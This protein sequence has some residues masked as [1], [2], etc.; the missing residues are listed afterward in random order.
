MLEVLFSFLS[1]LRVYFQSSADLRLEL[2]AL[3]HQITVLQ[4]KT[5]KPR[6]KPADRRLWAWLSRF[7]SRWQSAL[8]NE[9]PDTVID[10]HR[11]GFR[12]YLDLEDPSRPNGTSLCLAGDSRF[13]SDHE[14]DER[15]LGSP[16]NPQRTPQTRCHRVTSHGCEVHGATS[17]TAITDL[18]NVPDEPRFAIGL[19]RFLHGAHDLVRDCFCVH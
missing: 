19:S 18:E 14:S 4:R 9:K 2:I 5:P 6:L 16:S 11:R 8:V 10:W 3:R 12:W 7:W 15:A 1:S 13:D 17:K